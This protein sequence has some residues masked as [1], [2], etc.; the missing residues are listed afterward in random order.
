M[1]YKGNCHD[2]AVVESLFSL[3]KIDQVKLSV[4]DTR[5]EARFKVFDY[6]EYF[7]NSKRQHGTTGSLFSVF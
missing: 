4:F 1:T 2:N 6:S 7:Y 3:L 5:G